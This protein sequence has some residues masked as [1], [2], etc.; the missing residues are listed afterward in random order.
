[1][2]VYSPWTHDMH[3]IFHVFN[4]AVDTTMHTTAMCTNTGPP[5]VSNDSS[6]AM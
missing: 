4:F 3:R 5:I 2:L 6:S 1:M